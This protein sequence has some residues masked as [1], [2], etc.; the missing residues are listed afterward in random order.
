MTETGVAEKP[1]REKA[2]PREKVERKV[3]GYS[4]KARI[5][6]G[7]DE[8]GKPYGK[9]N[10]PKRGKSAQRFELYRNGMTIEQALAAGLSSADIG[11]DKD[12]DLIKI[13]EAA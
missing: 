10:N 1:K 5:T 12:H 13:A 2:P 4:K 7:V 8:D 11:W 9:T 3:A 6:L